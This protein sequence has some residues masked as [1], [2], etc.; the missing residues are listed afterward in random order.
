[1]LLERTLARTLQ[2]KDFWEPHV[3]DQGSLGAYTY[4]SKS[5][6]SNR[7]SARI[8]RV[9]ARSSKRRASK[10]FFQ[11]LQAWLDSKPGRSVASGLSYLDTGSVCSSEKSSCVHEMEHCGMQLPNVQPCHVF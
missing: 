1:M 7:L 6:L 8:L 11:Y 5:P 9:D 4:C 3:L 10:R 2:F